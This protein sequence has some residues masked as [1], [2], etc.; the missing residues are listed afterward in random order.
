[1]TDNLYKLRQEAK[2]AEKKA[3][4]LYKAKNEAESKKY[5]LE[6]QIHSMPCDTVGWTDQELARH[7]YYMH[8]A[9][10]HIN[11]YDVPRKR[12]EKV[13]DMLKNVAHLRR[14]EDL[15]D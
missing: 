6:R 2:A 9:E 7:I 1:M 11:M 4:D 8:D 10:G 14:L 3:A 12:A 5:N 15:N 13:H